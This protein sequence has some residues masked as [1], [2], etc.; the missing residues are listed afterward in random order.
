MDFRSRASDCSRF[1]FFPFCRNGHHWSH[2]RLIS[3]KAFYEFAISVH[4]LSL[5]C[6]HWGSFCLFWVYW[7]FK[8]S[9]RN[10]ETVLK[11]LAVRF[12]TFTHWLRFH[13]LSVFSVSSKFL[14]KQNQ[15]LLLFQEFPWMPCC[16][17]GGVSGFNLVLLSLAG[18]LAACQRDKGTSPTAGTVVHNVWW[19]FITWLET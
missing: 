11:G 7:T 5:C 17:F 13:L 12:Y 4:L 1:I 9:L 15:P 16:G 6:Q 10:S 18:T 19:P 3:L 14:R 8:T 2:S